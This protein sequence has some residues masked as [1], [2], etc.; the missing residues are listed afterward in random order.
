MKK[1]GGSSLSLLFSR[2]PLSL[3]RQTFSDSIHNLTYLYCGISFTQL[4][5]MMGASFRSFEDFPHENDFYT[6]G[7]QAHS[8]EALTATDTE[9]ASVEMKVN[10]TTMTEG[11]ASGPGDVQKVKGCEQDRRGRSRR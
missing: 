1:W 3:T 10:D 11:I 5:T 4:E 9:S 2:A 8:T 6:S 7:V